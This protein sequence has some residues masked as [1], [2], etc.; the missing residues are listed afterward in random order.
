MLASTHLKSKQPSLLLLLERRGDI[1][2]IVVENILLEMTRTLFLLY[3]AAK[4]L[5]R[6]MSRP[7]KTA[8][9]SSLFEKVCYLEE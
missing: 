2:L 8:V 5:V 7:S 1:P 6:D 9:S 3:F 4:Y